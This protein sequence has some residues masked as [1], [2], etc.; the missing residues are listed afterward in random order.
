MKR[1]RVRDDAPDRDPLDRTADFA[2]VTRSQV[3]GGSAIA[4]SRR[5]ALGGCL[6]ALS[7]TPYLAGFASLRLWRTSVTWEDFGHLGGGLTGV[8]AVIAGIWVLSIFIIQRQS[9]EIINIVLDGEIHDGVDGVQVA[10][11][12]AIVSNEGRVRAHIGRGYIFSQRYSAAT[13]GAPTIW[14]ASPG[15]S[16]RMTLDELTLEP[17]EQV[18]HDVVLAI[19]DQELTR[20]GVAFKASDGWWYSHRIL[21]SA[22]T[23]HSMKET[24]RA[25]A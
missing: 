11:V 10:H 18:L 6:V 14:D 3:Q 21:S 17:G 12:T 22:C 13:G 24:Q 8:A 5:Q 15:G 9:K 20:I 23:R 19:A 2:C 25:T 16:V 7:C 1:T 4:Y